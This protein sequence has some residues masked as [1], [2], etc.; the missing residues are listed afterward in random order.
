MPNTESTF[1]RSPLTSPFM[2]LSCLDHHPMTKAINKRWCKIYIRPMVEELQDLVRLRNSYT[3]DIHKV[4][5][6][7]PDC[8][9][10]FTLT[11]RKFGYQLHG[12]ILRKTDTNSAELHVKT[13]EQH[14]RYTNMALALNSMIGHLNA[15]IM[16]HVTP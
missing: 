5:P 10:A 2:D 12:K 15:C 8:T 3:I 16:R 13:W 11:Q 9:T 4:D 7:D 1:K 14:R 6:V